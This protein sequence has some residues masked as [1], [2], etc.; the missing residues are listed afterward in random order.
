MRGWARHRQTALHSQDQVCCHNWLLY[1]HGGPCQCQP[2]SQWYNDCLKGGWAGG[3]LSFPYLWTC[4]P[5]PLV[6]PLMNLWRSQGKFS[7]NRKFLLWGLILSYAPSSWWH[8]VPCLVNLRDA[9]WMCWYL[10]SP[11]S[12]PEN[13][14][15]QKPSHPPSPYS[16]CPS[17][18]PLLVHRGA[19]SGRLLS[20]WPHGQVRGARFVA[21]CFVDFRDFRDSA[22][23]GVARAGLSEL[24]CFYEWNR[25]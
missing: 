10:D 8:R 3:S 20:I 24:S 1:P 11:S 5:P 19:A 6:V 7:P 22:E 23:Y 21:M 2:P 4:L 14:C 16:M 17:T 18:F 9:W 12:P 15:L 25:G 13:S